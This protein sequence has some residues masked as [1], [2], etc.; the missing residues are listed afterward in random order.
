MFCLLVYARKPV[1]IGASTDSHSG[2]GWLH[3]WEF[4]R[5]SPSW[6]TAPV[7]NA[8]HIGDQDALSRDCVWMRRRELPALDLCLSPPLET[9]NAVL[10]VRWSFS[11]LVLVLVAHSRAAAVPAAGWREAAPNANQNE[12]HQ[13]KR[14]P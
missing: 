1:V 6:K 3:R 11:L 13:R 10:V 5:M 2:K 9:E 12:N 8:R 4:R 7:V 14:K